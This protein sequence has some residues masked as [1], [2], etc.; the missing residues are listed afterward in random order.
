MTR[1]LWF[2][3]TLPMATVLPALERGLGQCSPEVTLSYIL[4]YFEP[5]ETL[6]CT[7]DWRQVCRVLTICSV[8]YHLT[9]PR[10][11]RLPH[12]GAKATTSTLGVREKHIM[13]T[14]FHVEM[15]WEKAIPPIFATQSL[16]LSDL[17]GRPGGEF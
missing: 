7:F 5:I 15:Y 13:Q 6:S 1:S 14:P 17:P 2:Y 8:S 12:H 11:S 3:I 4:S 16:F 9:R 10:V